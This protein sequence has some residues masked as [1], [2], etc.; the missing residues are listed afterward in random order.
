MRGSSSCAQMLVTLQLLQLD[1]PLVAVVLCFGEDRR[2]RAGE[3]GR[4]G[5][6]SRSS[7]TPLPSFPPSH[8]YFALFPV[9]RLALK[10]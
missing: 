7:A 3:E 2:G 1:S 9:A 4:S 5:R 6:S 10:L 8:F